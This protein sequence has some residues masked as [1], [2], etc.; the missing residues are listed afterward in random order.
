MDEAALAAQRAEDAALNSLCAANPR[1][2]A[3]FA[4]LLRRTPHSD[5][6]KRL[7]QQRA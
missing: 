3:N 4:A 5:K 6:V 1:E 2:A 7:F